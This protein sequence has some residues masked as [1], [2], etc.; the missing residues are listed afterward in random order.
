MQNSMPNSMQSTKINVIKLPTHGNTQPETMG[1][2]PHPS[3]NNVKSG[4]SENSGNSEKFDINA[5]IY[6]DDESK[7]SEYEDE[8]A[9]EDADEDVDEDVDEDE[10]EDEDEDANENEEP[11]AGGKSRVE[12][13]YDDSSSVSTADIL[14]KD[15]LFLVLSEFLM[16][17][18]GNTIVHALNKI[19]KHLEKINK[20]MEL[21]SK[22]IKH[23]TKRK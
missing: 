4:N 23:S 9:D 21:L 13:D 6:T 19:G 1:I 8:D 12:A 16:D 20:N 22:N 2:F 3:E 10:D 7:S 14:A 17:E 5:D 18:K 15:P 11:L